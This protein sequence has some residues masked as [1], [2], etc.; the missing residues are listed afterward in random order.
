MKSRLRLAG[1][2]ACVPGCAR[3]L[4][5]NIFYPLLLVIIS[6][7]YHYYYST[8]YSRIIPT[9]QSLM[10]I[11]IKMGARAVRTC[12]VWIRSS[13]HR[14][15]KSN[16]GFTKFGSINV[17]LNDKKRVLE[18]RYTRSMPY[19]WRLKVNS[20]PRINKVYFVQ[21]PHLLVSIAVIFEL[22]LNNI[23]TEYNYEKNV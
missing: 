9:I 3:N 1:G 19:D 18:K 11:I 22:R 5:R 13:C 4:V 8:L 10:L 15:F 7:Q 23:K 2:I 12:T 14:H 16:F 6:S 17:E 21:L 20:R